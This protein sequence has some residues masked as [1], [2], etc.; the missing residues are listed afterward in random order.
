MDETGHL[1]AYLISFFIASPSWYLDLTAFH[2]KDNTT[3]HLQKGLEIV[4]ILWEKNVS[5]LNLPALCK[6]QD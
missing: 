1:T 2:P 5:G 6:R 4:R 3:L